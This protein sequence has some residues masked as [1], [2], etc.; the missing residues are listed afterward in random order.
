LNNWFDIKFDEV[1]NEVRQLI[2]E[3]DG[4]HII[5]TACGM[6]AKVLIAELHKTH[7]N[8]IY[9]DIGSG[10]DCICTKR[11]SRGWGYKYDQIYTK[12]KEHNFLPDDWEDPKY[13]F[14]YNDAY[15][16]LGTHLPK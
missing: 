7:P 12:F 5:L 16:K 3:V 6:S 9:L 1:V 13:D 11:D 10:L 8:G 15:N 2:G 4:N 14:I